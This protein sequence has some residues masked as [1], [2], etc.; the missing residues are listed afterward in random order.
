MGRFTNTYLI[1]TGHDTT[2]LPW[3]DLIAALKPCGRLQDWGIAPEREA[4]MR[5]QH[6]WFTERA[7]RRLG[8]NE[9]RWT[10]C[11]R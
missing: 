8:S 3:W 10:G 6:R 4:G 9:H 1:L 7:M 2:A 11:T 5:G